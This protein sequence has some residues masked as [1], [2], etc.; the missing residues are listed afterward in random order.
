M[1][2]K[3]MT[4]I[5]NHFARSV[6]SQTYQIVTDGIV[7][8]FSEKYIVGQYIWIKHSFINDGVYKITGV[9]ESKL[10]LDAT[11]L[12]ENTGELILLFGLAVPP[13]F[14][15]VVTEIEAYTSKD[16]VISESIGDYSVNYGNTGGSWVNA[17]SEKLSQWKRMFDDD[18]SSRLCK[19]NWQNKSGCC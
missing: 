15:T 19:R 3:V 11:L 6:E 17:F 2:N 14:L 16:G 4:E 8:S 1:L 5:K 7:G 13:D 10:T 12:E 18:K 9:T